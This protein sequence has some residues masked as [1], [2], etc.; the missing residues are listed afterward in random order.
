MDVH[1]LYVAN[2]PNVGLARRRIG[3][4]S[5]EAGVTANVHEREVRD[6]AEAMAL[7]MRGSPTV[8]VDGTDVSQSADMGPGSISCRLYRSGT[9]VDGAPTVAEL[10]V[11][12]TR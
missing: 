11:A 10:V 6:E 3:A 12:F 7:G 9:G 4:A 8:L 1:L 5:E 2:C